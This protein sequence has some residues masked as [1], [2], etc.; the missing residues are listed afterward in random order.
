[1]ASL[2][3]L[4][5]RNY[6]KA[7]KVAQ[8]AD[9]GSIA[10]RVRYTGTAGTPSV[11][12]TSATGVAMTDATATVSAP[13]LWS[14]VAT[15]GALADALNASGLWE[16]KILDA[17]RSDV[18]LNTFKSNTTVVAGTDENGVT[19][20][21]LVHDNNIVTNTSVYAATVCLSPFYNFNAPK[22]H[23]VNV[24]ELSYYQN[25]G[26][27]AAASVL[28]YKRT[29]NGNEVLVFSATSVDATIT[30]IT[31]ASGEGKISGNDNE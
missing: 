4:R 12:M 10:I 27:A 23:R 20:W 14:A 22:G 13:Y 29:G 8:R 30:A 21:D 7:G 16:A 11:V 3:G 5:V 24:Q 15:V 9:D 26:T 28:L 1:M 18:T 31:F 19:V 2:D 6:L 17:L 25:V